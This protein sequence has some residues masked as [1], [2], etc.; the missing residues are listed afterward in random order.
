MLRYMPHAIIVT[1]LT[2]TAW[3]IIAICAA[4]QGIGS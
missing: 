1:C 4:A 3:A 2:L